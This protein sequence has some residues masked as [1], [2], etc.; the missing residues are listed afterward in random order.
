[1]IYKRE[2]IENRTSGKLR[3][4][5]QRA[6][7]P[8]SILG[9]R[10]VVRV[11]KAKSGSATSAE[12]AGGCKPVR[13]IDM[14]VGVTEDGNLDGFSLREHF[15]EQTPS[16]QFNFL[17]PAPYCAVEQF[18]MFPI[19]HFYIPEIIFVGNDSFPLKFDI[20]KLIHHQLLMH[21]FFQLQH[22]KL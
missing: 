13:V 19:F 8:R 3:D 20:I 9:A 1:M 10:V 21:I 4:C 6:G 22:L 7:V 12:A 2:V 18:P 17:L 5:V 14:D 15:P 16:I 11:N